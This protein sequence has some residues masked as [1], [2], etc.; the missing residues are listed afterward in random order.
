MNY[1]DLPWVKPLHAWLSGQGNAMLTVIG[2]GLAAVTIVIA[3]F[4]PAWVKLAW[5]A[6]MFAP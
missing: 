4:A 5:L 3:L 1:Y 6:Y 2:L